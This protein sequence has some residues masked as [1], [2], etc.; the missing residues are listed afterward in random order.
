MANKYHKL[1]CPVCEKTTTHNY[2]TC[3]SCSCKG[4]YYRH[5]DKA[6]RRVLK[7]YYETPWTAEK[8]Y[9]QKV[10]VAKRKKHSVNFS[11]SEFRHWYDKNP[12]RC[13]YCGRT[14]DDWNRTKIKFKR[15]KRLTID[16]MDNGKDYDIDNICW[17]CIECN[18]YK[19]GL[20]YEFFKKHIK[21]LYIQHKGSPWFENGKTA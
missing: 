19:M 9:T 2:F 8:R 20:S 11:A 1:H 5:H 15:H 17:C 18:S 16:R 7:N 21:R 12:M 3:C 14:E 4:S 6:K 10:Q 13:K